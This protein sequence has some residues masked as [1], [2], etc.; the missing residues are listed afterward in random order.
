[1]T[2]KPETLIEPGRLTELLDSIAI[3][4]GLSEQQMDRVL[5]LMKK[6]L[7]LDGD[8]IFAKGDVASNI[9]VVVS[10]QVRLDF[11]RSNHPLSEIIF[12]PGSCF[13]ETS[14]IGIQPHSA[15]TY[16]VGNT[17]LLSLSGSELLGLYERDLDLFSL[18]ILNIARE[19]CRRLHSTDELFLQYRR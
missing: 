15:N 14:L 9:Y 10:G 17:E 3:F 8:Q 4:G 6:S 12:V 19:A 18:L 2:E 16:A 1:V 5:A 13:G 11:E 7:H